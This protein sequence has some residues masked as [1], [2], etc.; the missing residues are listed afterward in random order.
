MRPMLYT[1]VNGNLANH[2]EEELYI[3]PTELFMK[4]GTIMEFRKEKV[5]DF[6]LMGHTMLEN[7]QLE[8][9]MDLER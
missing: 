4:A 1:S 5:E 7:S 2:S 3:I 8:N 9:L 6:L